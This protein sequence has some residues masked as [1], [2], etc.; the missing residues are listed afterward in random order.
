MLKLDTCSGTK[1]L[2][3]WNPDTWPALLAPEKVLVV[4]E[5]EDPSVE[6]WMRLAAQ[7]REE[8]ER[9][10]DELARRILEGLVERYER[11]AKGARSRKK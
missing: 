9:T 11:E 3:C 1:A 2:F 6:R 5:K 7:A 8:A 10:K 4:E